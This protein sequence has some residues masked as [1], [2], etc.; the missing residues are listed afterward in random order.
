MLPSSQDLAS[1]FLYEENPNQGM[2]SALKE[3]RVHLTYSVTPQIFGTSIFP[4]P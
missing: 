3:P 1:T 2:L 4:R